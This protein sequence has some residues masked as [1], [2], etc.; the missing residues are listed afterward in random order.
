MIGNQRITIHLLAMVE[1]EFNRWARLE[2]DEQ[3]LTVAL[4]WLNGNRRAR[5]E[6]DEQPTNE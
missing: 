6:I 4:S 2:I 5:F 1:W 3:R